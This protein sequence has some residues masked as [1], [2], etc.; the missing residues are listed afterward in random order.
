MLVTNSHTDSFTDWIVNLI[1]VTLACE[2]GN[3]KLVEV[4]TVVD[5]DD[6]RQFIT[7]RGWGIQGGLPQRSFGG[8]AAVE[9]IPQYHH[10]P[11]P[12]SIV[13]DVTLAC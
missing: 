12:G 1:D 8:Q 10:R 6:E 3:S 11:S 13:I 2:D 4:V 7:G 5:V 9:E